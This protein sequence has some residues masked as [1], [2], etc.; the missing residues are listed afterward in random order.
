M[1]RTGGGLR[2]ALSPREMQARLRQGRTVAEVAAEAGVDSEWVERFAG[3]IVAER[4][5]ALERAWSLHLSAASGQV[6]ALPLAEAVRHNLARRGMRVEPSELAEHWSAAHDEDGTW[7]VVLRYSDG[8]KAVQAEWTADLA[9][10]RLSPGTPLS[11][12]LGSV[13]GDGEPPPERPSR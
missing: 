1:V 6:S 12:Q 2:G 10:G 3:P 5:V 8:R 13:A 11:A 4:R 9:A 7:K